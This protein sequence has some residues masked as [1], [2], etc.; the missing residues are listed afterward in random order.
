V[1]RTGERA[2]LTL[3]N[4]SARQVASDAAKAFGVGSNR[5][6]QFKADLAKSDLSEKE[7]GAKKGGKKD[8]A[9]G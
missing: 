8:K 4:A 3:T 1:A 5:T 6:A 7:K 2:A 9:E